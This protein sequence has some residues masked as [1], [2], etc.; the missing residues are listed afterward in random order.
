M[1]VAALGL[2]NI[3]GKPFGNRPILAVHLSLLHLSTFRFIFACIIKLIILSSNELNKR[4][5]E[6][7]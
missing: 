3:A 7:R 2:A 1:R 6:K 4:D 5:E